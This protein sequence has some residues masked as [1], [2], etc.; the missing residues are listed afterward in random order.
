MVLQIMEKFL[1]QKTPKSQ[2]FQINDC[3]LCNISLQKYLVLLMATSASP[4]AIS[5]LAL[6]FG[7]TWNA[8]A[9]LRSRFFVYKE[10]QI[11]CMKSISQL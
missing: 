5:H 10:T 6:A 3:I 11:L 4:T 8:A 9:N 1:N 7:A 2:A